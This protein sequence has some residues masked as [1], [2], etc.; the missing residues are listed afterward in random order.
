MVNTDRL[1]MGCMNDNGGEKIC[2]ICGH[3][4]SLDNAAQ[5][6]S[7]GTWL[8]GNRY[9]VGKVT[10]ENG[11]SVVY[12]GWDN[13]K[14]T[15]VNIT[16]YLPAGLARRSAD[17]LTVS[18]GEN[19]GLVF[20]RGLEEFIQ[21]HTRL[22]KISAGTSFLH[23]IDIFESNGTVYSVSNTV[24]S[25][26]L[27]DFLIR[28]GG[29]L[30]WE[31]VRPLFMSLLTT[32]TELHDAGIVHRGISLDTILVGRD[33]RLYL[34]GF[35]IK[36]ARTANNEFAYKLSTGYSAPE[37]YDA[38]AE[39]G[40][41]SDIYALGAVLFRCVIGSTP[42]DAKE[43]LAND[44]LSIPANAA[45]SVSKAALTA[46]ANALKVDPTVRTSSADRFKKMIEAAVGVTV[47]AEAPEEPPVKK[48]KGSDGKKYAVIASLITA[49]F[50]IGIMTCLFFLLDM[51]GSGNTDADS[52]DGSSNAALN[53]AP[54]WSLPEIKYDD[55]G[56]EVP[57][58]TGMTYSDAI[59]FLND[60]N[61][62]L[63]IF[64]VEKKYSS[65]FEDRGKIIDQTVKGEK[66]APNS[67]IGVYVS[68]GT[69]TVR[70]PSLLG[71]TKDE[72]YLKLLE[73]GFLPVNIEFRERRV[74]SATPGTV[75]EVS[76]NA[77]DNVS[78]DAYVIVDYCPEQDEPV[79]SEPEPS[80][81]SYPEDPDIGNE[82]S[83]PEDSSVE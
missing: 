74:S 12:I 53:S 46:I 68:L 76:V 80:E 35:S 14:N 45:E 81:P 21:L 48:K 59:T 36:S 57:D 83:E 55:N 6:L 3:D 27:K 54:Q 29:T 73:Y 4:S 60:K 8:N 66:V 79:S 17:R 44:K 37:Q 58:L 70:M 33:G 69:S 30:K 61:L 2:P 15:I 32:L 20:N 47:V 56:I 31:Q 40:P 7:I 23:V 38:D 49:V 22:S 71:M 62:E 64:I 43:R 67:E 13:D 41:A 10:E 19:D 24:S 16:E 39:S 11:D 26:S 50:F 72:A 63:E 34:T 78:P 52:N 18:P 28:N 75:V 42:P 5:Y 9:L 25:I 82:S 51:G 65:N 77:G 1:C